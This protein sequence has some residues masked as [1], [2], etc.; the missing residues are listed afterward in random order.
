MTYLRSCWYLAA[1]A[2]EVPRNAVLARRLLDEPVMLMRDNGGKVS[3][4]LDRCP[5]R[6]APLSRGRMV[7]GA[8]ACT[9]HG[10]AFDGHGRCVVNPH[11]PVLRSMAVKHYPVIEAHRG[12][13]IWMGDP[14]AATP[15]SLRDLRFLADAPD[16]AFSK[17][18]VRGRGDYELFVDNILDLTHADYLHPDT[19]GGGS[20]TRTRAKIFDKG[21]HVAVNWDCVN[22]V[23]S[24]QQR[25]T[26]GLGEDSRVDS[27]VHVEWSA[28]ATLSLRSGAVPTGTPHDRAGITTNVH[29]MTPESDGSTHYF[30]AATRDFALLDDA[31]NE[32]IATVRSHVFASEDKPMIEAQQ[33]RIGGAGF[34]ELD[35]ILLRI[36]EGAVR[37]RRKLA[38]MIARE[39]EAQTPIPVAP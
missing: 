25:A 33:D 19:L 31:L 27:W 6:F 8:I 30:F 17:G 23:P 1:W 15:E 34:W 32:R 38:A 28:P 29:I 14:D 37:V 20:L 4:L 7:D 2:D 10:L 36:D 13:W 39:E 16:S 3:A 12:I 5:H 35:P 22:E 18:Y 21:D 11:G 26:R 9:Y 24:P